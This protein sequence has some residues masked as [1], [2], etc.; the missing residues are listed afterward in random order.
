M[1]IFHERKNTM[2]GFHTR[3]RSELTRLG[4]QPADAGRA[5]GDP[6]GQGIRDISGGRKRLTAE[7]LAKL[8]AVGVDPFY[9]LTGERSGT[10]AAVSYLSRDE[11]W[12][13]KKWSGMN[14]RQREGWRLLLNECTAVKEPAGTIHDSPAD[15][16]R[17]PTEPQD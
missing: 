12:L 8:V 15:P 11:E 5:I 9:V 1:E 17:P 13:L 6:D 7:V 2:E 4:L 10:S 3:L 14:E 16:Y